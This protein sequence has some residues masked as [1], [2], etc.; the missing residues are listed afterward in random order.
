MNIEQQGLDYTKEDSRQLNKY[1]ENLRK[2]LIDLT[3]RNSLISAKFFKNTSS[4]IRILDTSTE[5]LLNIFD[6]EIQILE[7]PNI[8]QDPKDENT[9][10]FLEE[11]E[12]AKIEENLFKDNHSLFKKISLHKQLRD[13][14]RKKL[15]MLPIQESGNNLSE[16]EIIKYA[17]EIPITI[18]YEL[19]YKQE[20]NDKAQT[21]LSFNSLQKK[22]KTLLKKENE[23]KDLTG[24]SI[25]YLA[26][27]F[28]EWC[29]GLKDNENIYSPLLLIPIKIEEKKTKEGLEFFISTEE[30]IEDDFYNKIL[31]EKLK[32]EFDIISL[33]KY[34]GN[35]EKYFKELSELKP[36]NIKTWNIKRWATIG[37]FPSARL[38]MY[39]DLDTNNYDFSKNKIACDLLLGY[40]SENNDSLYNEEYDTEHLETTENKVPFLVSDADFSQFSVIID[41]V[42]GKNI[43][44]EGPPG[45]GK[46]Q[47][48]VNTIAAM[49]GLGKKVLFVAEKSAALNVVKSRLEAMAF[50]DFLLCLD[51]N[52]ST[53]KSVIDS[54]KKRIEDSYCSDNQEFEWHIKSL[55]EKRE[56]LKIYIDILTTKYEKTDFTIYDIL[57]RNIRLTDAYEQ[58]GCIKD[59]ETLLPKTINVSKNELKNILEK[60]KE[61]EES[62]NKILNH[63]SDY[64]TI[65]NVPN[66]DHFKIK[67]IIDLT[68]EISVKFSELSQSREKLISFD[69]KKDSELDYLKNLLQSIAIHNNVFNYIN[70]RTI[71]I[72]DL[73]K[74]VKILEDL[75]LEYNEI[76]FRDLKLKLLR[77][78]DEYIKIINQYSVIKDIIN[79][80]LEATNLK[81]NASDIFK[82]LNII[83]EVSKSL[84]ELRSKSLED[85]SSKTFVI[86]K[87]KK[88]DELKVCKKE[89]DEYFYLPSFL[90]ESKV[91]EIGKNVDVLLNRN[92]LSFLS[93]NYND[94][95]QILKNKNVKNNNINL[96]KLREWLD[97][98]RAFLE[99]NRIELLR[100]ILGRNFDGIESDFSSLEKTISFFRDIDE[101]FRGEN[102][103]EIKNFLKYGDI[104][105]IENLQYKLQN[106]GEK[107]YE[108]KNNCPDKIN[109]FDSQDIDNEIKNKKIYVDK[110]EYDL[111]FLG[112]FIEIFKDIDKISKNDLISIKKDIETLLNNQINVFNFDNKENTISFFEFIKNK[113]VDDLKNSIEK[114]LQQEDFSNKALYDL[115]EKTKTSNKD[116][117]T[118]KNYDQCSEFMKLASDD[119]DGLSSYSN[120]LGVKKNRS[121]EGY[122]KIID[123]ILLKYGNLSKI[124]EVL[125]MRKIAKEVFKK[126][127]KIASYNGDSLNKLRRSIQDI[128]KEI[129]SISKQKL[130]YQ[131]ISNAKPIQGNQRGRTSDYTEMGLLEYEIKKEKKA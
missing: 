67:E 124:I 38:S 93:K 19:L 115:C 60:C 61:I 110:L 113:S 83:T 114:I 72:D 95:K 52:N 36:K 119:I 23:H 109:N 16:K 111:N 58:L 68:K 104:D 57:S 82:I 116:W 69:I 103:V 26:L 123:E 12:K 102:S 73:L 49:L 33:P 100:D 35:T 94:A 46:S 66:L 9:N 70:L 3:K 50:D 76:S 91:L 99:D 62:F 129:I 43:V 28:L 54:I 1:I 17:S 65:I 14:V 126:H 81:V 64:W 51:S 75:F 85:E 59:L 108:L 48:I 11:L 78:K 20:E 88:A 63:H 40:E 6:N 106:N 47:T 117:L 32:T 10:E 45:T 97:Y 8:E 131:L 41:V 87:I 92:F 107:I 121:P 37:V 84:L 27:G 79:V 128:D 22:V 53:K 120:F 118:N 80:V 44:V 105:K 21:L 98:R 71:N 112:T 101:K 55:K 2:K 15:N 96:K 25:L 125:I 39:N 34:D 130:K 30:S 18:D 29:E 77:E 31:M 13:K 56:E 127:E 5:S 4:Y 24:I 89:L 42:N 90:S 7:L 74:N 122:E 86:S